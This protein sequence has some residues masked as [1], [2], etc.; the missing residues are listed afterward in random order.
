[1]DQQPPRESPKVFRRRRRKQST[2]SEGLLWS[3]LRAKQLCGLKFRRE[4]S[5]EEWVVD[6]ACVAKMLV[7]EIDGDYHDGTIE[8]DMERQ[9]ELERL[10]W[11]VFRF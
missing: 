8:Q 3:I 7:V 10:G 2:P 11:E 4:Y 9:R 5:I 1:M 6:F